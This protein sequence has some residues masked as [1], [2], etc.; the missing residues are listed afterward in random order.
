MPT[1]EYVCEGTEQ[2][3]FEKFQS[4][5]EPPV[6]ECPECGASVHRVIFAP[7]LIFKGPGFFRTENRAKAEAGSDGESSSKDTAA[8]NGKKDE[9]K[10]ESKTEKST[11]AAASGE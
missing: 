8:G 11:T 9:K 6:Q 5:S 1:Y 3:Q 4:F 10:S 7:P 2:H